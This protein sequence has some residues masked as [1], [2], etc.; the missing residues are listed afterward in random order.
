MNT[1][2]IDGHAHTY[3]DAVAR[4]VISSFTD[5]HRMH[6]TAALGA[7]TVDDLLASMGR[8]GASYTVTANFAPQK[9]V[10]RT[11]RWS[12]EM[13]A[14]HR[15]LIPLV[16]VYP[17]TPMALVREYFSMGARGIKLH[18]GIQGFEP[19]DPGLD[20]VYRFCE[21]SAV[22]VTFHCGE[23]SRVHMNA[24]AEMSHILPVLDKHPR[25]SVV[26]THLAAGEPETVFKI[27]GDYPN[28]MFDT[29]ITFSGE[30]CIDRIHDD[31]W[32]DD[33]CAAEGFRRIGCHRV[34]FGSD[35][36]FGSPERDVRRIMGLPLT[37]GEKRMILG[38]NSW[39]LYDAE[40]RLDAL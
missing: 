3:H 2:I 16:C 25:L 15:E 6:P 18:T 5:F 10:D 17:D 9:S 12:L 29:S 28:A 1:L 8:S 31:F 19:D 26:L 21:E 35:Y 24:Y 39:R 11:N 22:P 27:A 23:T 14:A 4:R 32:E 30:H 7:G 38:L 36:P 20:A 13:A 33:R 34:A 40:K 37:D